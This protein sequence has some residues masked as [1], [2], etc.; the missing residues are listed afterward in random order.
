M[1][2]L[3]EAHDLNVLPPADLAGEVERLQDVVRMERD[4][5]LRTLADFNNYR[6]RNER[7]G[8]KLAE[9]GKRR[10]ILPLLEIVDDM[11]NA[12]QWA[13]DEEQSIVK[14]VQIIHKKLLALLFAN[15]VTPFESVGTPFDHDVHEA[16]AIASHED[17]EPGTVVDQ[18]RR[19]YLWHNEL[20]RAAQ[21]RVVG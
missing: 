17:L 10:I 16:V 11:E 12:V 8:Q 4:R 15:G 9:E 14:G 7:D 18:L 21:V 13:T 6:R 19:G 20:L 2:L 1:A 3:A 5:N